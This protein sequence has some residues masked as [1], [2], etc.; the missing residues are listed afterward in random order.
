MEK[1][2]VHLFDRRY[3]VQIY[4]L[5]NNVWI[6]DGEVFGDRLRASGRTAGKA[7]RAW[8]LAAEQRSRM[9]VNS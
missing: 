8:R 5:A 9:T 2:T 7:L 1:H 6:A 3:A 4:K